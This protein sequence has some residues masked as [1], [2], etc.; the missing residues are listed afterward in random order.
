MF[1]CGS[2][3]NTPKNGNCMTGVE[4][5]WRIYL[6]FPDEL[7]DLYH[8]TLHSAFLEEPGHNALS[9]ELGI[10]GFAALGI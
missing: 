2:S 9:V 10:A 8:D 6:K 3:P 5:E 7:P 4:T 1:D